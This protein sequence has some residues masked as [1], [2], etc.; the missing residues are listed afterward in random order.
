MSLTRRAVILHDPVAADAGP[1]D[2]DILVQVAAVDAA[3]TSSGW[4]TQR[5][6]FTE[7]LDQLRSALQTHKPR[8]VFNLVET[9]RGGG[10]RIHLAP[11]LLAE[12]SMPFTGADQDAMYLTSNKLISKH[13]LRVDGMPTPDWDEQGSGLQQGPWIVKSVW[14]DASFALDDD[15]LVAEPCLLQERLMQRRQEHGGRWFAECY[16]PGREFNVAMLERNGEC[17]VLP[18]AEICFEDFPA[19]L[20]HIVG[21]RAKWDSSSFEYTHTVRRFVDSNI[22]A[23]LLARLATLARQCWHLFKLRGY[24]RVDFRVDEQGKPWI[25]EV[26]ANPCLSPDAGFA[27]ALQIAGINLHTAISDI[28]RATP[29]TAENHSEDNNPVPLKRRA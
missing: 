13:L 1:D 11:M 16:V 5:L 18:I 27:A 6:A 25:L 29:T 10:Q 12:L 2:Q 26:N 21:Y 7:D 28:V 24:A 20:P 19:E 3:L 4:S 22:E 14:E 9:L 23:Q 17:L 15:A 8:L